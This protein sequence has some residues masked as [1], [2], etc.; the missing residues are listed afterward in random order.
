MNRPFGSWERLRH[1]VKVVSKRTD[2]MYY[3]NYNKWIT[4]NPVDK[5]W[6]MSRSNLDS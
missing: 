3:V 2:N 5:Y 4:P 6:P 1:T